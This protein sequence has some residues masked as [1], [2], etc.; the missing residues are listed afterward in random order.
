MNKVVKNISIIS[1]N[2]IIIIYLIELLALLFLP[3][4]TNSYID[5]DYLRNEIANE[6]GVTFDKRT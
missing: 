2:I 3:S 4:K 6:R 5:I 1:F